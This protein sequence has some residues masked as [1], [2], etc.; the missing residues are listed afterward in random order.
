M[1]K[2]QND[3][4]TTMTTPILDP[5]EFDAQV[6]WQSESITVISLSKTLALPLIVKLDTG[7]YGNYGAGTALDASHPYLLHSLQR[8][9]R[10]VA[11]NVVWDRES[12]DFIERG[13]S[14]SIPVVYPG[15]L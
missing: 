13:P 11:A 4:R 14:L 7:L 9:R 8:G 1:T 6:T 15:K 12:R 10:V 2:L 3:N 5:V